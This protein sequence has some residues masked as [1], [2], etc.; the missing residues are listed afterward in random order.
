M[1]QIIGSVAAGLV[2]LALAA[3]CGG[4]ATA[5]T[6]PSYTAL[7]ASFGDAIGASARS[8]VSPTAAKLIAGMG[9]GWLS[10]VCQAQS[11]ATL[12]GVKS[13]KLERAFAAGYGK[14]A[15]AGSPA[16]STV[17]AHILGQ[18]ASQGLA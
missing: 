18:C 11:D 10:Q 2:V 12:V 15:P 9:S 17:L 6:H 13:A 3:G 14:T 16:A 8:T 7:N 4:S 1:K 5:N